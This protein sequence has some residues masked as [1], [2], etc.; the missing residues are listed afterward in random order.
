MIQVEDM[1]VMVEEMKK[2]K[3]RVFNIEL[4]TLVSILV[5]SRPTPARPKPQEAK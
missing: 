3:I 1:T 4:K 5:D 2:P